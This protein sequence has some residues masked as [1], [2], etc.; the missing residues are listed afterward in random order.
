MLLDNVRV[1]VQVARSQTFT[2]AAR[3]LGMPKST[4][5][6]RIRA[7]EEEL[8]ADLFKRTT[9]R[10]MLTEAGRRY[11]EATARLLSEIDVASEA[12]RSTRT[13]L[14][15]RLRITAGVDAGTGIVGDIVAAFALQHPRL[16]VD[17]VLR[18]EVVDLVAEEIDVAIRIGKLDDSTLKAR[19]LGMSFFKLVASPAYL[20]ENGAPRRPSD[21]VDHRVL[22]F[23][24]AMGRDIGVDLQDGNR[25]ARIVVRRRLTSNQISAVR[26]QALAGCGIA[27]LPIGAC[28]PELDAGRLVP[29][30]KGWSSG[31][32]PIQIVYPHQ[33]FVPLKVTAFVELAVERFG[34]SGFFERIREVARS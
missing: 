10:M 18:G 11:F 22:C 14:T 27:Y 2:D 24:P 26:H 6:T 25:R 15:G 5:S 16:D 13:D 29:V 28:L 30:L 7:L 3:Q 31:G 20:K 12:V 34:A 21:V 4:V 8:G 23:T 17:Y 9:R 19:R 1:F 32:T 33:R